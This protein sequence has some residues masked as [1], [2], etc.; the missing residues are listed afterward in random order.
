[1]SYNVAACGRSGGYKA[2]LPA[3]PASRRRSTGRRDGLALS[4]VAV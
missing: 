2:L 3:W 1:V 4:G